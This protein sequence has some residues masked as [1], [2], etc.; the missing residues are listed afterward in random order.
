MRGLGASGAGSF[1]AAREGRS[2]VGG[3]GRAHDVEG[4]RCERELPQALRRRS[5]AIARRGGIACH[6][7]PGERVALLP[8]LV[9]RTEDQDP[10]VLAG[11]LPP[12]HAHHDGGDAGPLLEGEGPPRAVPG[13]H[14]PVLVRAG[15]GL[16]GLVPRWPDERRGSGLRQDRPTELG[17]VGQVQR[18]ASLRDVPEEAGRA[19][20][21]ARRPRRQPP[22]GDR[23]VLL[24]SRLGGHRRMERY[25]KLRRETPRSAARG[26]PD[27]NGAEGRLRGVARVHLGRGRPVHASGVLVL[28]CGSDACPALVGA[29]LGGR[30]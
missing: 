24:F 22:Q 20:W 6:R 29:D 4:T 14:G 16:H 28:G 21:L 8:P 27:G 12:R 13:R 19:A 5:G 18:A 2:G 7:Q 1:P 11:V 25:V 23:A 3:V 10:S 9:E 17:V 26:P 15:G 30:G